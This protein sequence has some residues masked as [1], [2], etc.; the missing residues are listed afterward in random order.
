MGD[1]VSYL[2]IE[3]GW[4]VIGPDGK[5][6]GKVDEVLADLQADIFHGLRVNGE[7]IPADRVAEIVEGEIRLAS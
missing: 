1:P 7:E 6:V 5:T 2:L 3:P 4:K